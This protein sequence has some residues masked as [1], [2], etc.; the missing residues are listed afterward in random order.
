M[1]LRTNA[2]NVEL[3]DEGMDY[4]PSGL[5]CQ[6]YDREFILSEG[7]TTA[8][9][10]RVSAEGQWVASAIVRSGG[11]PSGIHAHSALLRGDALFLAA[12]PYIVRL[13]TPLLD[14]IRSVEVDEATCFGVQTISVSSDLISHGE[15]S[16]ARI[17]DDGVTVWS[18]GGA[19]VFTGD[20][21]VEQTVVKVA[22][23]EGRVYAF[24]VKTGEANILPN[25]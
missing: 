24:D 17:T 11:G 13:A 9:G 19:D 5:G 6:R 10:A 25:A 3:V 14:L 22:D 4:V 1:T 7:A 23:F 16:I 21:V 20:L 12:G 8:L 2:Y 18:R 15:L